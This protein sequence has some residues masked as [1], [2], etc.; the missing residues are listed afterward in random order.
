MCENC[1]NLCDGTCKK[2]AEEKDGRYLTATQFREIRK[3]IRDIFCLYNE[4]LTTIANFRDLRRMLKDDSFVVS[5][6]HRLEE[7]LHYL[8]RALLNMVEYLRGRVQIDYINRCRDGEF[9]DPYER[10]AS[11]AKA[12]KEEALKAIKEK[13]REVKDDYVT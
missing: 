13:Y 11:E 5:M 12:I 1:E 7:G 6:C 9:I 8:A 2:P 4:V 10:A 3:Y